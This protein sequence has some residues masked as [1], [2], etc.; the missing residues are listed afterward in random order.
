MKKSPFVHKQTRQVF[1]M[2]MRE[3]LQ[4]LGQRIAI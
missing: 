1:T 2:A 4:R 3:Y